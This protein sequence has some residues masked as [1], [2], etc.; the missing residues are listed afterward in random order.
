[1]KFIKIESKNKERIENALSEVNGKS[2]SFCITK[3]TE[4]LRVIEKINHKL[5]YLR[6]K[7]RVDI[8]ITYKPAGAE[9]NAY[10][11]S[12]NTTKLTFKIR[13]TG[14]FLENIEHDIVFPKE[15]EYFKIEINQKQKDEIINGFIED[16]DLCIKEEK[17]K[18]GKKI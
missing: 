10:K 11:Y 3:F 14:F 7:Q 9:S 17:I 12:A 16:N 5:K 15:K 8:V 2:H 1:M 4:I 13:T 18:K 6:I